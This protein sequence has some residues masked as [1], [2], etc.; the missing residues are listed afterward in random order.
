MASY[1]NLA[2]F[3]QFG[4]DLDKSTQAQLSRGQRLQEILKQPQ[5]K[6]VSLENQVMTLF[7]GTNGYCDSVDVDKVKEWESAMLRFM[8]TNHPE[9]GK[10]IREK[11]LIS[12]DNEQSLRDALTEF[13]QTWQPV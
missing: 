2:A 1:R 7:A 12:K 13:N 11:K 10:D 4:S 9:I 8:E 3:A 6:P 5:Y